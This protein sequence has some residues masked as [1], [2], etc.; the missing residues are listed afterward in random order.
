MSSS[1]TEKVLASID[2]IKTYIVRLSLSTNQAV[3][4]ILNELKVELESH[5]INESSGFSGGGIIPQYPYEY[6][7]ATKALK[8]MEIIKSLNSQNKTNTTR[9]K[10][11]IKKLELK[12]I[13]IH[14]AVKLEA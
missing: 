5:E 10:D 6:R 7:E 12:L 1:E 8:I 4:M 3:D 2:N 9:Y 11:E 14:D 13:E